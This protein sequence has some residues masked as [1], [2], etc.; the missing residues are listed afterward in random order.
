[1][2]V[3]CVSVGG[4]CVGELCVRWLK[5]VSVSCVSAGGRLCG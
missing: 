2:S 4:R 1:M 3:S 5:I